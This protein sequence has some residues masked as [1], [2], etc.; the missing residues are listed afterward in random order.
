[1]LN[2][3]PLEKMYADGKVDVISQDEYVSITVSQ[4][5]RLPERTVVARVTGD[6]AKNA[7]VAPLWSIKKTCVINEI[8][9]ELY[10]RDT[11]QG[12]LLK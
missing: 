1:M 4:I 10:K 12:K 3:T 9:K 8:D 7:L 5:E 11:Y 2:G 6:G